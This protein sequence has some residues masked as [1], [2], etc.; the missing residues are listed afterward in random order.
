MIDWANRSRAGVLSI[1]IPSG[2]SAVDGTTSVVE[3]EPLAVRPEMVLALA[4]PTVGLL[5]AVKEGEGAQWHISAVDIGINVALGDKEKV[6][7]GMSWTAA[8]EFD[9]GEQG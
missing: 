2:F 1:N 9:R 3:G 4:A 7:F 8:L 6:S 5:E